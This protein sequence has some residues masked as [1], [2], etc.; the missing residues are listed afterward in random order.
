LSVAE[1]KVYFA[2]ERTFIV[3]A[4][5]T[6]NQPNAS[7]TNYSPQKWLNFAILIGTIATTLLNFVPPTDARGL[8]SAGLFT[9]A[10]LLAIAYS[11]VIFVYRARQLRKR[12]AEGMYYDKYGPTVLCVVL[13]AALATNIGLRVAEMVKEAQ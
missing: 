12:H 13:F 7:L 1:P 10:A 6:D 2:L 9:L 4:T 3:S 8:I 11:A 5:V